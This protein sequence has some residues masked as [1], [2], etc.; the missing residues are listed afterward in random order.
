VSGPTCRAAVRSEPAHLADDRFAIRRS[1]TARSLWRHF[2]CSCRPLPF[3]P[4]LPRQTRGRDSETSRSLTAAL[5][6][7][8]PCSARAGGLRRCGGWSPGKRAVVSTV[9]AAWPD[10][11]TLSLNA[12]SHASGCQFPATAETWDGSSGVTLAMTASVVARRSVLPTAVKTVPNRA[13]RAGCPPQGCRPPCYCHAGLASR[14]RSG[15]SPSGPVRK[16]AR[17]CPRAPNRKTQLGGPGGVVWSWSL[18][19]VVELVRPCTGVPFGYRP[20]LVPAGSC[21]GVQRCT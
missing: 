6:R 5:C 16:P 20:G 9:T 1:P 4:P 21:E 17:C 12:R 10:G 18:G 19:R 7:R 3:Q 15:A 8:P 11:A 14:D 13:L 2:S